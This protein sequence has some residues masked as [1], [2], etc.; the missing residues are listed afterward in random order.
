M[1]SDKRKRTRSYEQYLTLL[2][3]VNINTELILAADN[4]KVVDVPIIAKCKHAYD[5][6]SDSIC[7]GESFGTRDACQVCY[8]ILSDISILI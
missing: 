8:E 3:C 4:L 1:G 5:E 2:T 7:A 6:E